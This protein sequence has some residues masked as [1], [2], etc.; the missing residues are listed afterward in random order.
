VSQG[1]GIFA[2]FRCA[3]VHRGL[4]LELVK[5]ELTAEHRG[6]LLG[7][8]WLVLTPL[9][10]L[11]VY[12][13]TFGV[14]LQVRWGRAVDAPTDFALVAF[15]SLS[16]FW[17]FSE[18]VGRAHLTI[19][20]NAGYVKR[21]VFPL[22]ILPWASLGAALSRSA[23]SLGVFTLFHTLVRGLP[24]W[25]ALLIPLVLLPLVLLCLGLC[26]FL[27]SLGVYLRDIG[28]LVGIF[29]TGAMFLSPVFYPASAVPE[30]WRALV[31]LNPIAFAVEQ[32]RGVLI[33]GEAPDWGRLALHTFV[34]WGIA[35]LGFRWFART[36]RGFAD[37][38]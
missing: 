18:S 12:T 27:A 9:L 30:A 21:S 20:Q 22:E 38:L 5:R 24:P 8:L 13:F 3:W 1:V 32:A 23:L 28:P 7:L 33:F 16:V 10:L 26:W 25:T 6:A 36:R 11:C 37:V 19:L 31:A 15:A 17:I 34:A 2:P 35:W 29:V 14:V 4:L